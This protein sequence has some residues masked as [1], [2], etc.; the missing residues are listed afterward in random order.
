L[1]R[2]NSTIWARSALFEMAGH[3][4]PAFE[5][6]GQDYPD[7]RGRRRPVTGVAAPQHRT[8]WLAIQ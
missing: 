8:C 5:L 7:S 2:K 1:L 6:E 4:T 3:G